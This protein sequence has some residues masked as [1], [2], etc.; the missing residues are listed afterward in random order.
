MQIEN[1]IKIILTKDE[2]Q[3]LFDY[4]TYS[5]LNLDIPYNQELDKFADKFYEGLE[6]LV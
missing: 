6:K 1:M 3:K 5:E 2:A 4:M